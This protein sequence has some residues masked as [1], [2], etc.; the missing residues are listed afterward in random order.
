MGSRARLA[1]AVGILGLVAGGCA[2]TRSG[3]MGVLPTRDPLV[4]L[5]VSQQRTIVAQECPPMITAT[6]VLGCQTSRPVPMPD[7]LA[8][9][10]VKIVRYA[11]TLPSELA[12]EIDLHE[13]CHAIAALQPIRDP[14]HDGNGGHVVSGTGHPTPIVSR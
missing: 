3:Q 7:G 8:V 13:L 10:V 9:R 11:D 4:T 14:C 2:S 6:P 12:F 5:V 1:L